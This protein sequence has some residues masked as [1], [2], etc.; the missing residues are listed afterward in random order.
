MN[1]ST[2]VVGENVIPF[3]EIVPNASVRYAMID[4][5]GYLSVRDII[6][7]MC[8]SGADD[9]NMDIR[10][11]QAKA[12]QTWQNIPEI[13][14][15]EVSSLLRNL[16]FKGSGQKPQPVIQFQGALKLLMWLP[17][18][19]AKVMRSKAADILTRYFAGDSSLHAEVEANAASGG[20]INEA[21][22]AALPQPDD[23]NKRRKTVA[24]LEQE[25]AVLTIVT[26]NYK[27]QNLS[28]REQIELKR[29]LFG[30]E[31]SYERDKLGVV[32][33][34]RARELEHDRAKFALINGDRKSELEFKRALKAIEN[35]SVEDHAAPPL[36]IPNSYTTV[37]KVFTNHQREFGGLNSKDKKIALLR[38]AGRKAADAFRS[39]NGLHPPTVPENDLEVNMYPI[40]LE[41]MIM[42]SLREAYRSLWGGGNQAPIRSYFL[43]ESRV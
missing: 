40:E 32:D 31:L 6:M 33:Q 20:V 3:N 27:E 14:K 28:L 39:I 17:G 2:A 37:L 1:I 30:I 18:T 29:E 7:A 21:A 5:V 42:E 8:C 10:K 41:S 19:Q 13:F 4:G 15:S 43:A 22:R 9:A 26:A 16:Q 23:S 36:P 12:S 24:K 34:G 38:A 25:L 11:K 35:G